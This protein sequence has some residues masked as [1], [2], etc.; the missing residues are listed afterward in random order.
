MSYTYDVASGAMFE[1]SSFLWTGYSGHNEGFN[2]PGM[3]AVHAVGPIPR[4]AWSLGPWYDHPR[5]GPIVTDLTPVGHNAF[6]RT[7]FLIHGDN[8]FSNQSASHGCIVI[9]RTIR[10]LMRESGDT[11]LIVV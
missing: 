7:E 5:L 2:N 9:S 6:G 10:E 4:G 1:N 8:N 11:D 3:E